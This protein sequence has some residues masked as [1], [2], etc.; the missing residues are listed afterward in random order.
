MNERD[1]ERAAAE[2]VARHFPETTRF[3]AEDR[4]RSL[5]AFGPFDVQG[6][7]DELEPAVA[8][9]RVAFAL[10]RAQLVTALAVS[11]AGIAADRSPESLT[12]EDVWRE[13]EGQLAADALHELDRQMER[14]Q[15]AVWPPEQQRAV[16]VLAAAVDQAYSRPAPAEPQRPVYG[17]GTVTLQTFDHGPVVVA[18]PEWCEGHD[19][20]PVGHRADITHRGAWRPFDVVVAGERV[21]VLRAGLSWAPFAVEAP[22]PHPVVDTDVD[23]LSALGPDALREVA[24]GWGLLAGELYRLANELHRARRWQ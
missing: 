4:V 24:A 16:D 10:T 9:V 6:G 13:V 12:V 5:P 8:V 15:A 14:D 2:F 3:V 19:G 22:Q 7:V 20:E 21:E 17:D 18:E 23:G 1:E 11:F